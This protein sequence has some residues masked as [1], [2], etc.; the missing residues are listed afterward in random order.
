MQH[1]IPNFNNSALSF[2][3]FHLSHLLF[4][5]MYKLI[6]SALSSRFKIR[7]FI[8]AI[9]VR[10]SNRGKNRRIR[11]RKGRQ[12]VRRPPKPY[13][14]SR[15]L[16]VSVTSSIAQVVYKHKLLW[17]NNDIFSTTSFA[18]HKL[19]SVFSTKYRLLSHIIRQSIYRYGSNKRIPYG[20]NSAVLNNTTTDRLV[21]RE[22][23]T[24]LATKPL[25]WKSGRF[26]KYLIKKK[27]R[28]LFF[29]KRI[30][31]SLIDSRILLKF[32]FKFKR[33]SKK[34]LVAAVASSTHST[35]KQRLTA[36][37][38]SAFNILLRSG[39][40]KSFKDAMVWIKKGYVFL[41]GVSFRNPFRKLTIYDR[42]QLPITNRYFLYKRSRTTRATKDISKLKSKL[43]Y[44][45]QGNFN[46][47]RRRSRLW[48]N[49]VLRTA[50]FGSRVPSFLEVDYLSMMV[51]ILF[52][53][54][55]LL[56]YDSPLWRYINLSNY[57]L[58]NW[59]LIN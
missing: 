1:F 22:E 32:V 58:Y 45:N 14:F 41:N 2:V 20:Y 44:K 38:L 16:K 42:L 9:R 52:L 17:S 28:P 51:I 35:L 55:R 3:Y 15:L 47:F 13:F 33:S 37:E 19:H 57:R 8:G 7:L 49:W 48:P 40:T 5:L 4:A 10:V 34:N 21:R 39:L 6:I 50:Y 53:P 18:L 11:R 12:A 36:L 29:K 59:K 30:V 27:K 24:S 31:R 56:E 23:I 43:F 46:L 25:F 26:K 54:S